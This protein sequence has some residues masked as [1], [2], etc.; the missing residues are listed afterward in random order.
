MNRSTLTIVN[1][2]MS[3]LVKV[4][5]STKGFICIC[6]STEAVW[7][8]KILIN[9]IMLSY[10]CQVYRLLIFPKSYPPDNAAFTQLHPPS[11]SATLH[12]SAEHFRRIS[13]KYFTTSIQS[14]PLALGGNRKQAR[15]AHFPNFSS[16]PL[17]SLTGWPKWILHLAYCFPVHMDHKTVVQLSRL[18]SSPDRVAQMDL[19]LTHHLY[20]QRGIL[21]RWEFLLESHF[22]LL[23][24]GFNI[25]I[26]SHHFTRS[27]PDIYPFGPLNCTKIMF[28]QTPCSGHHLNPQWHTDRWAGKGKK[29]YDDDANTATLLFTKQKVDMRRSGKS[30]AAGGYLVSS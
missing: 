3:F 29:R 2:M 19:T 4:L 11:S 7:Q 26:A 17:D 23:R 30:N 28:L 12:C 22:L 9:A 6:Q 20:L 10:F 16:L 25:F 14:F 5:T 27:F 13:S 18:F 15:R 1:Q 24:V 8:V 21:Q